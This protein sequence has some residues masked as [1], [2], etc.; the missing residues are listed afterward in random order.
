[1][2]Q[3]RA[4]LSGVLTLIDVA[5]RE[6]RIPGGLADDAALAAALGWTLKPEGLCRGETC[7]PLL[8]RT[9]VDALGLLLA[10]DEDAGVA[11]VAPSAE[12]HQR[13]LTG[14]RAPRLDLQDV[15]GNPVSF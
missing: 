6:H 9:V 4:M 14:G 10:Q 12:T 15:D 11:A 3:F 13:E 8:G 1:M 5:G 2:F 7:V